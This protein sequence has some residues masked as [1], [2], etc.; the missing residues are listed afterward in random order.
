MARTT[1]LFALLLCGQPLWG[2]LIKAPKKIDTVQMSPKFDIAHAGLRMAIPQGFSRSTLL[3]NGMVMLATRA[4]TIKATQSLSVMC[5]T[6]GE[7]F[8]PESLAK[9][10][11]D[12]LTDNL[13]IR[14]L[15]VLKKTPIRVAGTDGIAHHLSYTQAGI[16]TVSIT[17]CLI[18][19]V[20][21]P[22]W[23]NPSIQPLK[24]FQLAYIFSLEIAESH[25]E[26]LHR[27]FDNLV[28]TIEMTDFRRPVEVPWTFR[29]AY[30]KNITNGV[31]IRKPN[32]WSG[33]PSPLGVTLWVPDYRLKS[34]P[35]PNV[36]IASV[37]TEPGIDAKTCL[38]RGIESQRKQGLVIDVLKQGAITLAKKPGYE[39]IV[40]KRLFHTPEAI[41]PTDT[42]KAILIAEVIE[43][44]RGVNLPAEKDLLIKTVD[45]ALKR[46]TVVDPKQQRHVLVSITLLDSTQAQATT[47]ADSLCTSVLI[48]RPRV[49]GAPEIAPESVPRVDG[50]KIADPDK[51]TPSLI[52]RV[53]DIKPSAP[54]APTAPFDPLTIPRVGSP[55]PKESTK[56]LGDPT[57]GI[58]G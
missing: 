48:F 20:T 5:Y 1:F 18:R 22:K 46:K 25:A 56:P 2:E 9:S 7:A 44:L 38:L 26:S 27:T 34:V 40:R 11:M 19:K 45:G 12:D 37:L 42:P 8:T 6:L 57:K 17:L 31:G 54:S 52:P 47:L 4:E 16:K 30:L 58:D 21:P 15:K 50:D 28:K 51:P 29:G 10:L 23:S 36:E 13:S 49:M 14:R 3:S 33:S 43:V 39:F 24:P 53:S 35:S 41:A 32:G 55:K